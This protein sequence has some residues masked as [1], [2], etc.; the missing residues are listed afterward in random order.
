[1]L[2]ELK[3]ALTKNQSDLTK[4]ERELIEVYNWAN[5][6]GYQEGRKDGAFF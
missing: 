4:R 5:S 2:D 6:K 1:M 3:K